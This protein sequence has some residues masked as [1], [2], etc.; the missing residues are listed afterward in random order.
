MFKKLI[1][2]LQVDGSSCYLSETRSSM[3]NSGP[4][5]KKQATTGQKKIIKFKQKTFKE[6][7]ID[8]ELYTLEE[9]IDKKFDRT[10]LLRESTLEYNGFSR[11]VMAQFPEKAKDL[12]T[13][14]REGVY[15]DKKVTL[16]EMINVLGDGRLGHIKGSNHWQEDWQ[17]T[18]GAYIDIGDGN[19]STII[20]DT[21]TEEFHVM[22]VND[23]ILLKDQEYRIIG[24]EDI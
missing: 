17:N 15:N 4:N 22:S 5:K 6:L 11:D 3:K 10:R 21:I 16:N 13:V 18:V 23:F 9:S 24:S 14:A 2:N 8:K 19:E 20:Y 7:Q 12:L 1:I